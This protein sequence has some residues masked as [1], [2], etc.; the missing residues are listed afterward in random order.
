MFARLL[1]NCLTG[2]AENYA[3]LIEAQAAFREHM[4]TAD[5]VYVLHGLMTHLLNNN[6]QL[7]CSFI[8][9]SKAFDYVVRDILWFKLIKYGVKG[10][11]L[12]II[13]SMYENIKSRV[14]LNNKLSQEFSCMTGVRQG[15]CLS[16]ILFALYVNDLEQELITRDAD[17]IDTGLLKFF[18]LLYEDDIV[19][20]S[21]SASGL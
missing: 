8:D 15:E 1:N 2:W 12:D 13:M 6:R 10:K 7:Y 18:L 5:N 14:K 4:C 11:M 19:I 20:F 3:V 17:D 9:F 21:E 16:P